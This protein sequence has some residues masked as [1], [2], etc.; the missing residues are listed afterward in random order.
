[1]MSLETM[2]VERK[3]TREAALRRL[4][5]IREVAWR[6]YCNADL[7]FADDPTPANEAALVA[8]SAAD[9]AAW[10]AYEDRLDQP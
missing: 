10:A 8:A 1:M 5:A 9:D 6:C 3:A 7:A 2:K 4:H